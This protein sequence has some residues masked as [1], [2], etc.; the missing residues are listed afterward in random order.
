[1]CVCIA[2]QKTSFYIIK[3]YIKSS[4]KTQL[5]KP[6]E[7]VLLTCRFIAEFGALKIR[8]YICESSQ[9]SWMLLVWNNSTLWPLHLLH[10]SVDNP[11]IGL[12][13]IGHYMVKLLAWHYA[14]AEIIAAIWI[15]SYLLA[16][17][18]SG[19]GELVRSSGILNVCVHLHIGRILDIWNITSPFG[20]SPLMNTI[21]IRKLFNNY[22]HLY[23][24]LILSMLNKNNQNNTTNWSSVI[25]NS[26]LFDFL[27]F[28]NSGKG[29]F[30]ALNLYS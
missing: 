29:E 23:C 20:E 8:A 6:V 16:F 13:L 26:V 17:I 2:L 15:S 21:L 30:T 18:E 27:L 11:S 24:L 1:M 14:A 22:V 5:G 3:Y 7:I 19:Q 25:L 10:Q 9:P 28:V 4:C 12:Y